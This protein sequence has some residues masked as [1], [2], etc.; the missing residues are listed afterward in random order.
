[1]N[2]RPQMNLTPA[3][4]PVRGIE[5]QLHFLRCFRKQRF[6]G[7]G[8]RVGRAM[9][10]D[11][12]SPASLLDG[13]IVTIGVNFRRQLHHPML[14]HWRFPVQTRNSLKTRAAEQSNLPR[15]SC[16]CARARREYALGTQC[17]GIRHVWRIY[18]VGQDDQVKGESAK[19]STAWMRSAR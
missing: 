2:Y 9:G 5:S 8:S 18:V 17:D 3:F 4:C 19:A 7:R 6:P 10:L 12:K 1:M 13:R 16:S 11:L 14:S 15:Y